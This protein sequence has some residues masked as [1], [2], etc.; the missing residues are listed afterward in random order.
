MQRTLARWWASTRDRGMW[1]ISIA[2]EIGPIT[3]ATIERCNYS[4]ANDEKKKGRRGMEEQKVVQRKK[5]REGKREREKK[6]IYR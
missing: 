6:D 4:A 5:R 3:P 2:A 1:V